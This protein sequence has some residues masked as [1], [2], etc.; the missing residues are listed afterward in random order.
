MQYTTET[1]EGYSSDDLETLNRIYEH[2][3]AL[4]DESERG[5]PDLLQ[6]ISEQVL[7]D[8]DQARD[9]IPDA[10]GSQREG[11][12]RVVR[13]RDLRPPGD[14]EIVVALL[15]VQTSDGLPLEGRL[16]CILHDG[17]TESARGVYDR[18]PSDEDLATENGGG[19]LP[20]EDPILNRDQYEGGRVGSQGRT[21]GLTQQAYYYGQ[22][23]TAPGFGFDDAYAASAVEIE[24]GRSALVYWRT[25][26]DYDP[27]V[28]DESGACD[29]DHPDHVEV[30]DE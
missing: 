1:T 12:L 6:H 23:V 2:R 17:R 9:L 29:W 11:A 10:I 26:E 19:W 30:W 18:I 25:R 7:A 15:D 3:I 14:S 21:Y 13:I 8:Y 4:L 28:Q 22:C 16:V 20:V 27:E 5:N 24:T